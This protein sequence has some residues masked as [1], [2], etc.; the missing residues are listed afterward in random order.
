M[1]NGER[2]KRVPSSYAVL[3]A[4]GTIVDVSS[5]WLDFGL[6]EGLTLPNGGVGRNY[7][8]YCTAPD[9]AAVIKQIRDLLGGVVDRIAFLYP[10]HSPSRRRWFVMIGLS[11]SKDNG[12]E[13]A[14][15]FHFDVTGL[16]NNQVDQM[17]RPALLDLERTLP[18][19][20]DD[21]IVELLAS[22]L[23]K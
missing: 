23:W 2:L 20:D 10:C 13:R 9:S 14:T 5:S 8:E 3:D 1:T 22:A 16:L 12:K 18:L 19:S 21:K 6:A 17:I 11:S 15:V 7:L 4:A